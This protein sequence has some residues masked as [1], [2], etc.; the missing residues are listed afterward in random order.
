MSYTAKQ[1][2]LASCCKCV[3]TYMYIGELGNT[4]SIEI[5]YM[6]MLRSLF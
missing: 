3:G 2:A 5:T 4:T 6:Y 1:N